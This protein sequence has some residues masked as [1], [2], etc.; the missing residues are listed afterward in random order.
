MNVPPLV[1]NQLLLVDYLNTLITEEDTLLDIGCGT[2]AIS[3]A[4]NAERITTL[5][6]WKPFEPDIW[7]DMGRIDKLPCENESFDVILMLDVIEHLSKGHGFTI[8]KDLKRI[9]R[10]F[11]IVLTPLWWDPNL[12]CVMDPESPYYEN[13]FDKHKSLWEA[14][15]FIG[16][17]RITAISS[18]DNYFLGIWRNSG[19]E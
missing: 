7:C 8:L 15:D 19:T 6:A 17:E 18:L 16:F 13:N 12:D 3:T 5:D 14:K 10:K 4:T 9:A 11:I 1:E 2:K